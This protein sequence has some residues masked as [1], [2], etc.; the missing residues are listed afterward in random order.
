MSSSKSINTLVDDIY[1]LIASGEFTIDAD[2][3]AKMIARRITEPKR[4]AY[5]RMSNFGTPC[6]RKLW[7]S[8]NMPE[9][10]EPLPPQ[11]RLKFLL[12]D[13]IEEVVLALAKQSGHSVEGEQDTLEFEGIKGHWDA[14]IDGYV[15]DV[16]SANSRSFS[17]FREHRLIKDDPF[18]YLDQ[19]S[20]YVA[21]ARNDT[22]IRDRTKAAFL[23]VDKELGYIVLD[24]YDVEEKDWE[25]LIAAKKLMLKAKT[26]PR[27]H[28]HPEPDGKSGNMKLC[29]ECSYC[30]HKKECWPGVKGYAYANKPTWLTTVKREPDVPR[31]L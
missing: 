23:A 4:D 10:A 3:L 19:I 27:R 25:T 31:I 29:M 22:R 26:P 1:G 5:L 16:K 28:Y 15:V 9:T 30:P 6:E 21:A 12:G 17:K 14:I 11:A 7:Y 8:I 18:G 24:T 20:L 2:H 13:I